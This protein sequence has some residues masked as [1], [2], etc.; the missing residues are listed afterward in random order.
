MDKEGTWVLKLGVVFPEKA[1]KT[2][3]NF[4]TEE[5]GGEGSHQLCH[6]KPGQ[7]FCQ[8]PVFWEGRVAGLSTPPS[9]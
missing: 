7:C 1:L 8:V 9:A 5:E 2:E 3:H 4:V 6:I